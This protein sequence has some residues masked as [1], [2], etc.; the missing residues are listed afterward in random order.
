MALSNLD[1][2]NITRLFSMI[3]LDS[4]K[5]NS[6][7]EII[8][9]DYVTYGKLELIA[10]QIEFLRC[11][12]NSILETHELNNTVNAAICNFK[13]VPGNYYYLYLQNNKYIISL[14]S[15]TEWCNYDKFIYKLFYDY[16]YKFKIVE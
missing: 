10:Q 3:N 9:Q 1:K 6:D 15:N 5:V 14:I 13:R 16:D 4:N 2:D 7:L 12:A 11:Q 8:R